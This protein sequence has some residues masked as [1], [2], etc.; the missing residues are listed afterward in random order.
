MNE[1]RVTQTVV[2][3]LNHIGKFNVNPSAAPS[4]EDL[5]VKQSPTKQGPLWETKQSDFNI[6][7]KYFGPDFKMF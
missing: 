1:N 7:Q 4:L 2:F 5:N 3:R 6:N